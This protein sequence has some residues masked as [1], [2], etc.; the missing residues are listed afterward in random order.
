MTK[1]THEALLA[2][3]KR[4]RAQYAADGLTERVALQ[5]RL[6]ARLERLIEVRNA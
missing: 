1:P 6:I 3:Y 4:T 2:I 5:D